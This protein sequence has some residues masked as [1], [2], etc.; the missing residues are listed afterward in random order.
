[1][2]ILDG[3]VAIITG[4]A[5]GVGR[6][7]ARAFA[8]EGARLVLC[9]VGAAKN[10]TGNDETAAE[11]VAQEARAL[12][13]EAVSTAESCATP[14]GADHCVGLATE[15]FGRLDALVCAAG[16]SAD[17]PLARV[18]SEVWARILEVEL[19][20]AMLMAQ[21]AAAVMQRRGEGRI[22]LTTSPAGLLGNFGQPAY[23]AVAA[24][25]YGLMRA[26]SIEL[27]RHRVF[28]NAVEPLAKTRLTEDLPLFEHVTTMTPEHVAPA[29]LFFASDLS[30]DLTGQV[31]AI[32]GGRISHYRVT[33]TQGQFKE[34][35]GGVWNAEE[36]RD[37]VASARRRG[38]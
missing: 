34:E 8:A 21:R 36:I 26:L 16:L 1:M 10:G 31:L 11:S 18:T 17:Q 35:G 4:A 30:S 2:G 13:A 3:K 29:Y 9:D 33:E 7:V 24:G 20:G 37:A 25:V 19:T 12:G 28:V 32:A 38:E 15:R 5:G 14:A 22:V 27:Q 6:A 23:S